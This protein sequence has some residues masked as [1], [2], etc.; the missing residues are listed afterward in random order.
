MWL[1]KSEA[2]NPV[3]KPKTRGEDV[4]R[5]DTSQI[6]GIIGGGEERKSEKNGGTFWRRPEPRRGCSAMDGCKLSNFT[7]PS[8]CLHGLHRDN[9]TLF[10]IV[11]IC[12]VV[13]IVFYGLD[14]STPF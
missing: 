3:G 1:R 6:L 8:A 14:F 13:G 12:L 9:L 10:L 2:I 4:V 5:R 7:S 11:N